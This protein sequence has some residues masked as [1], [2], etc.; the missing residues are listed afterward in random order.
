ML[1]NSEAVN[2]TDITS[3]N[4]LYD[5]KLVIKTSLFLFISF[6]LFKYMINYT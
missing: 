5:N 3:G 6:K 2:N 4:Y 1:I